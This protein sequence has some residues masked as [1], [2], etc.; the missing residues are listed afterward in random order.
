LE[1]NTLRANFATCGE[2]ILAWKAT[3]RKRT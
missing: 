1:S 2:I 3:R